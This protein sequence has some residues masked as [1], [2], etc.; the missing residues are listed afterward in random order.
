MNVDGTV[1][2]DNN[3]ARRIIPRA[4]QPPRRPI[5]GCAETEN[6]DRNTSNSGRKQRK[7]ESRLSGS[8]GGHIRQNI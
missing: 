7:S 1:L 5:R 4:G 8:R 2:I 6:R 3:P